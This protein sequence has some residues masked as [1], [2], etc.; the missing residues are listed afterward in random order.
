GRHGGLRQRL[1]ADG[2]AGRA[3]RPAAA[4]AAPTA[5]RRACGDAGRRDVR[6]ISS[7]WE[8]AQRGLKAR[9]SAL[10]PLHRCAEL[11]LGGS[12]LA[13][14]LAFGFA[15]NSLARSMAPVATPPMKP[16]STGR[17]TPLT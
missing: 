11:P 13:A 10:Q 3:L 8:A 2:A 1:P 16:P 9:L 5:Q 4:A 6:A 7:P 17:A 15:P 14:Q 12:I